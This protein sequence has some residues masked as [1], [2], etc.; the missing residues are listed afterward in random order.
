MVGPLFQPYDTFLRRL[1][2]FVA[3]VPMR[4]SSS[5]ARCDS[6]LDFTVHQARS[7]APARNFFLALHVAIMREL[8]SPRSTNFGSKDLCTFIGYR[9]TQFHTTPS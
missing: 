2:R 4:R 8:H 1:T 5:F 9:D 3:N 7:R 6:Q